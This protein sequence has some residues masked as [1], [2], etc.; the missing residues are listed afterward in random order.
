MKQVGIL[1]FSISYCVSFIMVTIT[2]HVFINVLQTE[3][4]SA[5]KF[6]MGYEKNMSF[7]IAK[8]PKVWEKVEKIGLGSFNLQTE[9]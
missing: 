6:V 2:R 4:F 8:S 7:L 3:H 1:Q 5:A 9:K